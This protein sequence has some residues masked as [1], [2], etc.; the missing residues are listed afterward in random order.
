MFL[1]GYI[2]KEKNIQMHIKKWCMA[3]L[4]TTVVSTGY[5]QL[6]PEDVKTFTLPNQMKFLVVEDFSIPNAN[7]Y[8]FWKLG[9]RN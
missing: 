5:S 7:M 2:V 9:S 3:A 6:K 8:L 1:I 4:M